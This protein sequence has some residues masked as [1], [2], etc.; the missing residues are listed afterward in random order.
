MESCLDAILTDYQE[1]N[2]DYRRYMRLISGDVAVIGGIF[3]VTCGWVLLA[4]P[5][6]RPLWPFSIAVG[7]ANVCMLGMSFHFRMALLLLAYLLDDE[8]LLNDFATGVD[9]EKP[10]HHADGYHEPTLF[11]GYY[12]WKVQCRQKPTT[13]KTRVLLTASLILAFLFLEVILLQFAFADTVF[14]R[15]EMRFG[16][17]LVVFVLPLACAT[18]I[19]LTSLRRFRQHVA[20]IDQAPALS[21]PTTTVV[22]DASEKMVLVDFQ[23]RNEDARQLFDYY[24]SLTLWPP[25][26]FLTMVGLWIEDRTRGWVF[27]LTPLLVLCCTVALLMV[28]RVVKRLKRY[29]QKVE[30]LMDHWLEGGKWPPVHIEAKTSQAYY[31]GFFRVVRMTQVQRTEAITVPGYLTALYLSALLVAAICTLFLVVK[32]VQWIEQ[33]A[34]GQPWAAALYWVVVGVLIGANLVLYVSS[35]GVGSDP[36]GQQEL[37]V[38]RRLMT[39]CSNMTLL[40]MLFHG[41][42]LALA[43]E[44]FTIW[45]RFGLGLE[46]TR[47]TA[48]IRV[49]TF[50]LRLHHGYIGVILALIA[51]WFLRQDPGVRNIVL[52]ISFGLVVSDLIHHFLVLWPVTGS[53]EIDL[54][55]PPTGEPPG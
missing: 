55:Y 40:S 22:P 20:R 18:T 5:D 49:F 37:H 34:P 9:T 7:L 43:I 35:R 17:L 24:W 36:G 19:C 45:C 47:D 38:Y 31:V 33:Q 8:K 41:L 25:A 4:Q 26:A 39:H 6:Q 23:Q 10:V 13:Q 11:V 28:Y 44:F 46:A 51:W 21:F 53:P 50:G 48:A 12:R 30:G 52:M 1:R 32:G 42:I 16:T 14:Q 2:A 3:G 54:F 27:V 29:L 15:P